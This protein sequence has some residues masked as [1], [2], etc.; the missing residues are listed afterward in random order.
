M[1]TNLRLSILTILIVLLICGT[2][3]IA[4]A[5]LLDGEREGFLLG[6]GAGFAVAV[7]G[8]KGDSAT[9]FALS[10]KIGY[11]ISDQMAIYFSSPVPSI[12]PGLG[13]MYF[14]DR[15]SDG[16]LTGLLGYSSGNQDSILSIAGGMGYKLQDSVSLEVMLGFNRISDTYSSTSST[17][18]TFNKTFHADIITI[19]G[20][21]NV[22]FY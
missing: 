21:F 3:L 22:Y 20:T 13:F 9:G 5:Q 16:Y 14:T 19:A 10:G 12:V 4:D 18:Y 17:G 2:P 6:V 1:K 15:N 8:G 7:S 11:G